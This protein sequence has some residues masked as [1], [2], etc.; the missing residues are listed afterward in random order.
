M[1]MT[2][3]VRDLAFAHGRH[4]RIGVDTSCPDIW[5]NN[6]YVRDHG[7]VR[8]GETLIDCS[9]PPLLD[10]CVHHEKHYIESIHELVSQRLGINIPVSSKA[11]DLHLTDD[12]KSSVPYDVPK[13]YWIVMAGGKW[14]ISTKWWPTERY[15]EVI[16]RM[17]GKVAFVQCGSNGDRHQGL[18]GVTN[19]IG[20]T[21]LR[22]FIRLIYHSDGVICPVTAAM[23]VA[24]ALEK[25]CVVIAGQREPQTWEHY[26]DH[27]YLTGERQFCCPISGCWRSYVELLGTKLTSPNHP[28]CGHSART[29]SGEYAAC[30]TGVTVQ[31]VLRAVGRNIDPMSSTP[32]TGGLTVGQNS[33]KQNQ[34]CKINEANA[35]ECLENAAASISSY[36]GDYR[37]RG[38]V[39]PAGGTKYFPCAWVC[40]RML[41]HVGCDLPIE[42]WHLGPHE[43]TDRMRELVEPF[44]VTCI[45]ALGVDRNADGQTLGGWELKPFAIINSRFK[46]VML[47]DAD[48][49]PVKDPTFLFDTPEYDMYGA[50]FWPDYGKLGPE[51]AIWRLTGVPFTLE[52]EFETGQIVVNKERCW[53]A[54]QLTMWM[55]RHSEF[56]YQ[57]I[58]GDKDTFHLAWRKL[59]LNYAM[60][61]RGIFPLE[62]VVMCQHDFNHHRLFQHRNLC[63][64]TL[65]DTNPVIPHF[66][67]EEQC[68]SFLE[69]LRS[70]WMSERPERFDQTQAPEWMLRLA[71]NICS[72]EWELHVAGESS[73]KVSF[74]FDGTVR[75]ASG[76]DS[77]VWS[78]TGDSDAPCVFVLKNG[79]A[80]Y[81]VSLID[82]CRWNGFHRDSRPCQL[83]RKLSVEE[84][85]M[86]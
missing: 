30:M 54:L 27:D 29:S 55:N 64:W 46:E 52:P 60:P 86:S 71:S 80:F 74:A 67:H 4:F 21:T 57:H 42:L 9:H 33:I 7:P 82:D 43:M 72:Q 11:G 14:D 49:V 38:I 2:A 10:H 53:D 37:D 23:H 3:A 32:T 50:I 83:R 65:D 28:L 79:E 40:I 69:E 26:P 77:W 12:E 73:I 22:E 68:L 85:V 5:S 81:R 45:D 20:Q 47:L 39:I 66:E 1:M 8:E 17:R 58:H 51:R 56:W 76:D 70:V 75:L 34:S 15:Q 78:I 19:L 18:H 41:R 35:R 63:K 61:T 44:D 62:Y 59:G 36:G 13:R 84:V 24:A 48:N 25:P 31:D 6:P 16:D